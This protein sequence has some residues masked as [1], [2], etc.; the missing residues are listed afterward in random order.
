MTWE[1]SIRVQSGLPV[2]RG[3]DMISRTVVSAGFLPAATILSRT[4][5]EV[6]IPY[7]GFFS[8][9][10]TTTLWILRRR[11]SVSAYLTLES[12]ST[13]TTGLDIQ[14]RTVL[15]IVSSKI[16]FALSAVPRGASSKEDGADVSVGIAAGDGG[17]SVALLFYNQ[18]YR[19]HC[20]QGTIR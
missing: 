3:P 16:A 6:T 19:I 1:H 9:M 20:Q 12:G 15:G 10:A 5:V 7:V 13:T 11:I 2:M 8:D 18:F 17:R 14:S 4:S